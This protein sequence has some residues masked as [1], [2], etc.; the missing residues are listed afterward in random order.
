MALQYQLTERRPKQLGLIVLQADETIEPDMRRL[1]PDDIELLVSRVPSGQYVT[2][3]SLA[4]MADV[5]ST[6]AGLLPSSARFSAVGYGC[7]SG[8]AN[9]GAAKIRELVR[10]GVSTPHV[11]E[12]V[13]ALVAACRHLNIRRLALVSPY[14]ES[15][16]A[17][18]REVLQAANIQIAAFSSFNEAEEAKVARISPLSVL[19]AARDVAADAMIDGIFLSCTN[20]R[21]LDILEEAERV[22]GKPVL[23]SN[24]VLGWHLCTLAGV[25]DNLKGPGMLMR[26]TSLAQG[27]A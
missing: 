26:G 3:E 13:S 15:V 1:L 10:E 2:S 22:I 27:Q 18:L 14:I 12:P 24:Q 7:T 5:L 25:A 20:L 9:I 16:S 23:S 8:T 11:T 21:T 4:S 6:A 19:N 17:K